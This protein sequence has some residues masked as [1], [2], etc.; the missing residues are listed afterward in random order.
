MFTSHGYMFASQETYVEWSVYSN[1]GGIIF[2]IQTT[3]LNVIVMSRL[4]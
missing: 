4:E 2:Y 1:W 3:L